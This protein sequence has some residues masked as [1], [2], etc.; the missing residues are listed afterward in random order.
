MDK[1]GNIKETL[2][3]IVLIIRHD[4]GLQSIAFNKHRDGI[5]AR[6]GLPWEQIK[7]RW[8]DSD[9]ASLKVY[10]SRKYGVYSPTKT[11]DAVLAVATER[12]YHPIKDYLDALPEWDGV[13][14]VDKLHRTALWIYGRR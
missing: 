6:D 5:D 10:L 3:N 13:Q 1:K 11:K 2:D 9:N 4:A 12:A 14:R 7:D 8:N